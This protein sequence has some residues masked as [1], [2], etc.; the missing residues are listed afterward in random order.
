MREVGSLVAAWRRLGGYQA[1][2]AFVAYLLYSRLEL[3]DAARKE[4]ITSARLLAGNQ[5]SLTWEYTITSSDPVPLDLAVKSIQKTLHHL[6]NDHVCV[7]I[8]WG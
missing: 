1:V 6:S 4:K 3:V 7:T 2:V 5:C 8:Q